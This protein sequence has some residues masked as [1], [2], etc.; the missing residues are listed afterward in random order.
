M[1]SIAAPQSAV[2]PVPRRGQLAALAAAAVLAAALAGCANVTK[3]ESGEALVGNRVQLSLP[4]A[5]NQLSLGQLGP[6][7]VWTNDGIFVDLLSFFVGVKDGAALAPP[8]GKEQRPLTFRASMQP[9]EVVGLFEG[10]YRREGNTFQLDRLQPTEFMGG[11]GWRFDYTVVRKF[12][13]VE[14]QGVGW[15]TVR[16]GELHAMTFTAPRLG[17]FA[18]YE[19]PVGRI[20]ASARLR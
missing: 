9:H 11:A 5:W 20:A 15:A 13:D 17:F 4:G 16:N 18:R 14:L 12:D 7:A 3:I 19:Q 6:T 1:N 8:T 10:W 2:H